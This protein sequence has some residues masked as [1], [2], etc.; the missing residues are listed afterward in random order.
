M[1]DSIVL[2]ESQ[3][4]SFFNRLEA[5][6]SRLE[7]MA[8]SIDS[9]HVATINAI[10]SG[11][12]NGSQA[13]PSISPEQKA[14]TP[15]PV[16]RFIEEFDNIISEDVSAFVAASEKLDDLLA[17]QVSTPPASLR[18]YTD[19]AFLYRHD[20]SLKHFRVNAHICL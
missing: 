14:P 11:A 3:L 2:P 16:P 17:G 5:A 15:E 8:T 7:D 20:R 10:T 9:E 18:N 13:S 19:I 4:T 6:T 12:T 1:Q